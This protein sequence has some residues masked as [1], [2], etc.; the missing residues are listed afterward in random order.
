MAPE[1]VLPP[2]RLKVQFT[3]YCSAC[4]ATVVEEHMGTHNSSIYPQLPNGWAMI[5]D[6]VVCPKHS[7]HVW[8]R[9]TMKNGKA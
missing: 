7:I 6:A 4:D 5:N 2:Y 3:H 1:W 9:Q 8:D